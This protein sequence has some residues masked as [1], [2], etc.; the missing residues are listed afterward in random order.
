[1]YL[2]GADFVPSNWRNTADSVLTIYF[3]PFPLPF[4]EWQVM[5]HVQTDISASYNL[6]KKTKKYLVVFIIVAY[7]T[8]YACI[9]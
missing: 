5:S 2:I 3:V 9:F 4:A 8:L 7:I 6:R 1:M